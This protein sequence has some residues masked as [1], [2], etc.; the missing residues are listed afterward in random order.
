M[1]RELTQAKATKK[2]MEYLASYQN[3]T[4]D[5]V[6]RGFDLLAAFCGLILLSPIFLLIAALI[7]RDSPGPVFYWGS[8]MG[9]NGR[10]FKMLKFR[11][12]YETEKAATRDFGLPAR[13]TIVLPHWGNGCGIPSSMNSLSFGMC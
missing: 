13:R 7:K 4:N 8:R 5:I 10:V 2:N 6:K 3:K 11:T 1:I 9:R 12:M